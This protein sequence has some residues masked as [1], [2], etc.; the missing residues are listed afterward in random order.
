MGRWFREAFTASLAYMGL[1]DN[2]VSRAEL[3]LGA[4]Q[5]DTNTNRSVQGS[6]N[7]M[8]LMLDGPLEKVDDVM[9]LNPLSV[10]RWLC[11]YPVRARSGSGYSMADDA[12][13]KRVAAL[14]HAL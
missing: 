7:R 2:Q 8:R 11:H 6:L 13:T 1:P 4:V 12:M 3:A 5:F 14:S 10:T 9:L